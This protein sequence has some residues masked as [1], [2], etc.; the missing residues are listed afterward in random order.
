[1]KNPKISFSGINEQK[2]ILEKK[3]IGKIKSKPSS[4]RRQLEEGF[5][6]VQDFCH[7][8]TWNI[9]VFRHIYLEDS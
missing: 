1:M 9:N 8:R 5:D 6:K 3:W 4:S 7:I 2:R